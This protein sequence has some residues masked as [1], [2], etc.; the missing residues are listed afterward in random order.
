MINHCDVFLTFY[1]QKTRVHK[2]R[3]RELFILRSVP[4]FQ[5]LRAPHP[6]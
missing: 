4:M 6:L 5:A 1:K 2:M 3:T